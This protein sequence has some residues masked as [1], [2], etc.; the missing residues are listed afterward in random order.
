VQKIEYG[1]INKFFVSIGLV[2]IG[3]AIVSPYLYLKEDFGIYLSQSEFNSLQDSAKALVID[4]QNKV[5]KMQDLFFCVPII[6]S[7]LGSFFL[8]IGLYRWFERQTKIDEKFDRELDKLNLEIKSLTDEEREE[9]VKLE[10]QEIELEKKAESNEIQQRVFNKYIAVEES[11]T[12][13]FRNYSSQNFEILSQQKMGNK[14]EIDILLRAKSK[15]F[16]DRIVEIKYFNDKISE[17]IINSTLHRFNSYV[18]YY[19]QATNKVVVPVLIIVYHLDKVGRN[20]LLG[21][22]VMINSRKSDFPNLR[23]LKTQFLEENAID[24]FDVKK[25]LKK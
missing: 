23:R 16:A 25:I 13:I 5:K 15:G 3:L 7:V 4:K 14:F 6:L 2:L 10:V 11:I 21:A 20:G 22:Q 12:E 8:V 18:T 1:D 9:K 19:K 24:K 17:S